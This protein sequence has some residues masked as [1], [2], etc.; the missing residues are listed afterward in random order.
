MSRNRTAKRM[1]RNQQVCVCVCVCACVRT[2][3]CVC[4][5]FSLELFLNTFPADDGAPAKQS[6]KSGEESETIPL[7]DDKSGATPA[8]S[9]TL[10]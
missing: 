8:M 1:T 6:L 5:H 7:E 9:S 10:V 3:A 4:G 2:F